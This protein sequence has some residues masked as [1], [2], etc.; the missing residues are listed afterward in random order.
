MPASYHITRS[1]FLEGFL[2]PPWKS[3]CRW[4]PACLLSCNIRALEGESNRIDNHRLSLVLGI[5]LISNTKV[6]RCYLFSYHQRYS[7]AVSIRQQ[8]LA[9]HTMYCVK[10]SKTVTFIR[11]LTNRIRNKPD[12]VPNAKASSCNACSVD[13]HPTSAPR[14]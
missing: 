14:L 11:T 5:Q 13:S 2:L 10:L 7:P 6:L 8:E 1:G 12:A 3:R 9:D 4:H